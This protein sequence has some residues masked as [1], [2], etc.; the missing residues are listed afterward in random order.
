MTDPGCNGGLKRSASLSNAAC[1]GRRSIR[2]DRG[3]GYRCVEQSTRTCGSTLPSRPLIL[4]NFLKLDP[5][6]RQVPVLA[7]R[8]PPCKCKKSADETEA[9][10]HVRW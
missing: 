7:C 1:A 5:E 2:R 3:L 9:A 4:A 6:T 8:C 10:A